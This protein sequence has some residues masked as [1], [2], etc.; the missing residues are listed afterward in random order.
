[1]VK[2]QGGPLT[3]VSLLAMAGIAVAFAWIILTAVIGWGTAD[4]HAEDDKSLLGGVT[5]LVDD[6]AGTAT[7]AS[8]EVVSKSAKTVV[9]PVVT[10]V[11]KTVA[12]VAPPAAPLIAEV[13]HVV[14]EVAEPVQKIVAPVTKVVEP[15]VAIVREVPVV[16]GVAKGLGAD[17]AV[18]DVV[19]TVDETLGAV[20]TAADPVIDAVD[21]PIVGDP[22]APVIP[23]VPAPSDGSP[24]LDG[25]AVPIAGSPN[26]DANGEAKAGREIAASASQS[27]VLPL[28]LPADRISGSP[29]VINTA[30]AGDSSSGQAIEHTLLPGLCG[31]TGSSSSGS[32]SGQG[33]AAV[34]ASG[35][36]FASHAWVRRAGPTDDTTPQAPT[37]STDVAPD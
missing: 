11:K 32:G 28:A 18:S 22:T 30:S 31:P 9:E 17:D 3:R 10:T 29:A 27:F 21:T 4:A 2:A 36:L 1:M 16:G 25:A 19:K 37:L 20:E 33:S 14:T 7:S 12:E 24:L 5:D 8:T 26:A 6:V 34:L 15:V 35:S 13:T 23:A